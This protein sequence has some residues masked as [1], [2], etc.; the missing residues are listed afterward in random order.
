MRN[1]HLSRCLQKSSDKASSFHQSTEQDIFLRYRKSPVSFGAYLLHVSWGRGNRSKV[2]ERRAP[3]CRGKQEKEQPGFMILTESPRSSCEARYPTNKYIRHTRRALN[4]QVELIRTS[5]FCIFRSNGCQSNVGDICLSI[6]GWWLG[7]WWLIT[8]QGENWNEKQKQIRL[9]SKQ[10]ITS[11]VPIRGLWSGPWAPQH[12]RTSPPL[13]LRP[14][15]LIPIPPVQF[16]LSSFSVSE[17]NKVKWGGRRKQRFIDSSKRNVSSSSGL[18]WE[19]HHWGVGLW[20]TAQP[21]SP[22]SPFSLAL[23]ADTG[24]APATGTQSFS[25]LKPFTFIRGGC[26]YKHVSLPWA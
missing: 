7:R 6:R 9:H 16:F 8:H 13:S 26:F 12:G 22:P 23:D 11:P 14:R 21:W 17:Q 18:S 4:K 20:G 10:T 3:I 1:K 24:P 5:Y 19:N 15:P 25:L 2:W